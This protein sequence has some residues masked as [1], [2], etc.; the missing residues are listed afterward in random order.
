M[1]KNELPMPENFNSLNPDDQKRY[2]AIQQMFILKHHLKNISFASQLEVIKSF[3]HQGNSKDWQRALVAGI[4]WLDDGLLVNQSQFRILVNRHKSGLNVMF[5]RENLIAETTRGL[6]FQK[7]KEY[8]EPYIK[9]TNAEMRKWTFRMKRQAVSTIEPFADNNLL[10]PLPLKPQSQ[11]RLP[12]IPEPNFVDVEEKDED[13]NLANA[14]SVF[15]SENDDL[16]E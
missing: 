7:L 15:Y 12:I 13:E 14:F 16:Y 11:F 1:L 3:V 4:C 2:Q 5:N 10:P 6:G 8:F 9:I